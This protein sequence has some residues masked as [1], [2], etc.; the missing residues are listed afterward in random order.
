M[1]L[2]LALLLALLPV[3]GAR[4]HTIFK[5][6]HYMWWRVAKLWWP[7]YCSQPRLEATM[8]AKAV[9]AHSL[10]TIAEQV[11]LSVRI[12]CNIHWLQFRIRVSTPVVD[13]IIEI[14]MAGGGNDE[15]PSHIEIRVD[16]IPFKMNRLSN[17]EIRNLVIVEPIWLIH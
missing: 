7:R 4:L 11:R 17:R 2:R 16:R 6:C 14:E 10:A 5:I 1:G 9:T 8:S 15:W 13:L 3:S 12:C